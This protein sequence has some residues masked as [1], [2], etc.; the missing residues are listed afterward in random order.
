M[1]PPLPY[2]Q[3]NATLPDCAATTIVPL[4]ALRVTFW[5]IAFMSAL[6]VFFILVFASLALLGRGKFYR[7]QAFIANLLVV[8]PANVVLVSAFILGTPVRL[9]YNRCMNRAMTAIVSIG[10]SRPTFWQADY[11]TL[12][13]AFPVGYR[14][15]LG[16]HDPMTMDFGACADVMRE[17]M[18]QP[19]MPFLR[20][21]IGSCCS[22]CCAPDVV[23]SFVWR[24][25]MSV[26]VLPLLSWW[27][28]GFVYVPW[29]A[30]DNTQD[31]RVVAAGPLDPPPQ[32]KGRVTV[33]STGRARARRAQRD[34]AEWIRKRLKDSSVSSVSSSVSSSSASVRLYIPRCKF[35]VNARKLY[36][37][38][39]G[40]RACKN[41]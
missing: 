2:L 11:N 5:A 36:G 32:T 39:G 26:T 10:T 37:G 15:I 30:V 7:A 21:C 6:A 40:D 14:A 35:L 8:L 4:P 13:K 12:M 41:E 1:K 24:L 31:N 3:A 33:P 34:R 27:L 20:R 25:F 9:V 38:A 28:I 22:K 16:G 23:N 17:K 19:P 18:Q 29:V